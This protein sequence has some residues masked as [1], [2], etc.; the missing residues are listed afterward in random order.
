MGRPC[1]RHAPV[2]LR[3]DRWVE[4]FPA[5]RPATCHRRSRLRVAGSGRGDGRHLHLTSATSSD[6]SGWVVHARRRVCG[7]SRLS[8]PGVCC[9]ASDVGSADAASDLRIGRRDRR[10]RGAVD[11]AGPGHHDHRRGS[12]EV[13]Y[14]TTAPG[15]SVYLKARTRSQKFERRRGVPR[16]TGDG[17]DT[18]ADSRRTRTRSPRACARTTSAP[19]ATSGPTPCGSSEFSI[20]AVRHDRADRDGRRRA[21]RRQVAEPDP[22][23]VPFRHRRGCR[24]RSRRGSSSTTRPGATLDCYDVPKQSATQ[25]GGASSCATCVPRRLDLGEGSHRLKVVVRD[26]AGVRDHVSVHGEGRY[27]SHR[28]PRT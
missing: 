17:S 15:T 4:P 26:A 25:P 1:N 10:R 8:Y 23:G 11:V 14:R 16:I 7:C 28:S 3:K 2:P 22:A 5:F 20:V 9:A 21:H 13:S 19:T 24:R 27:A 18:W 6:V 12:V